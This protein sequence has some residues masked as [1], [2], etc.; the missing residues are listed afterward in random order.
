M[1]KRV[2]FLLLAAMMMPLA[3]N[4]QHNASIHI[5]STV[6]ACTS[7]TWSVNGTTYTTSGVHTHVSGDTLF[8]LDL[9]IN[10][11]YNTI[12]STPIQ[13]GCTYTWG[14]SV[15]VTSGEHTQVFQSTKGCDSTV[16]ITLSLATSA[17]KSYTVTACE[18]Y[19]WKGDTLTTSGITIY[20]DT[21]NE[22]CD[23]LLTL[24]L[25]II[26]PEAKSYDSTIVACERARFRWSPQSSWITVTQDGYTIDNSTYST[27]SAALRNVFH[28]RTAERCFDSLV[29][30]TF[31]IKNKTYTTFT[32]KAC[33]SY[34]VTINNT[35]YTYLYSKNDT[36]TGM[37][38]ANG[39]DSVIYMNVTINRSPE[40][41]ITGDLRVA[42]GS[43]ATLYAN[44]NQNVAY[45]WSNG[46]TADSITLKNVQGNTDVSL[47]GT[48]N[49]TGC[50]NT[51][52]VTILA[53]LAIEEV[54]DDLL[55]L[56]PNP[57][58]AQININSAEELKNISVFN[59][60]GQQVINAGNTNVVDLSKLN[61]G[62][63]VVRIEM[64]NGT[65]ATRTVVLTK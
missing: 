26:E 40:V 31:N 23:S 8:I 46:S 50:E 33:D 61:N 63:Y 62:T 4:A 22:H 25:T 60:M 57:T 55:Q 19:I 10:P 12:I 38:G 29:T 3:M 20:E 48:N 16:T 13:G 44:S 28:P 35:E 59:L 24:N 27:S 58:T 52:T 14:D 54:N 6:N 7:Y 15:Y 42:P 45:T 34:T 56:Y 51:T 47:T 5:D 65:V 43:D 53:N 2:F 17:I 49:S 32:E 11:V 1:K 37:K 18:S 21:T 41:Y 30:I 39:C 36:I 9:T 64:L